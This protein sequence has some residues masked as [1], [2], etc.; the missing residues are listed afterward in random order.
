MKFSVLECIKEL[1]YEHECVIL[2]N[3]GGIITSYKGSEIDHISNSLTPP[4]KSIS[5]NSYLKKDDGLLTNAFATLNKSSY[6]EASIEVKKWVEEVSYN[7]NAKRSYSL[8]GIGLFSLDIKEN[9][10]SFNPIG[11]ENFLIES[12]G[13]P[14]ITANPIL[15]SKTFEKKEDLKLQ[16]I[17]NSS[18]KFISPKSRKFKIYNSLIYACTA[19]IFTSILLSIFN[20]EINKLSLNQASVFHILSQCFNSKSTTTFSPASSVDVAKTY[21]IKTNEELKIVSPKISILNSES[22]SVIDQTNVNET[23]TPYRV[24]VGVF[25]EDKN[26]SRM[27]TKL[28]RLSLTVTPTLEKRKN[29]SYIFYSASSVDEAKAIQSNLATLQFESWVKKL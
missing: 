18:P 5:F 24:V 26:A 17:A 25:K 3:F 23:I 8:E 4:T 9:K 10:I 12:Y 20:V 13:L 29:L 22:K 7:L 27:Y 1:L 28:E 16:P 21:P 2:P 15:R 6:S 11:T 19:L 14:I